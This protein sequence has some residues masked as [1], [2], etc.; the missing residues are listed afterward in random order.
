MNG[1]AT[2]FIMTGIGAVI[3]VLLITFQLLS[4]KS[5]PGN[6]DAILD[7]SASLHVRVALCN[8]GQRQGELSGDR[9]RACENDVGPAALAALKKEPGGEEC[10]DA[11]VASTF[12]VKVD[13]Y[14]VRAICER[15][16]TGH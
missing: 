11:R 13:P 14:E 16:R 5:H 2:S 3:V 7:R 6:G 10:E 4:K 9:R 8:D 15:L 1:K 12:S